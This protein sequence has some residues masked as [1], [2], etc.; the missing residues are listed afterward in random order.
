MLLHGA[1]DPRAAQ[2]VQAVSPVGEIWL[3]LL[4]MT[5]IPL[6]ITQMFVAVLSSHEQGSIAALGGKALLLFVA[7]MVLAAV[8][9]VAIAPIMVA[10]FPT[11]AF[12]MASLKAGAVV[13]E[14]LRSVTPNAHESLGAWLTGLIPT[15]V[16]QAASGS[17][18]LPL[19]VFTVLFALAATR[20]AP[21]RLDLLLRVGRA[22]A[23][24]S[25]VVVR[26]I[27]QITPIGV[28]V[29]SLVMAAGAGW[30]AAGFMGTFVLVSCVLMAAFTVL[31]Y[32]ITALLGRVPMR[33]FAQAV[34]PAQLV[35][36][37]TRSSIASLPALV[38]GA[39]DGLRLPAAATGFVLPLTIAAF[40]VNMT[41]TG[42]VRLILITHVFGLPLTPGIIV[43]LVTSVI[44]VSFT[45][46]G[47]PGGGGAMRNLPAYL[48]AGLPIEA[49]VLLE[50][51][52]VIPDI[53]KTVLNVTG[54][55]SVATILSRG[56]S[57][58]AAA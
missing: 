17:E 26:W 40:R 16:V 35:A 43:T 57:A 3:R 24:M 31:L 55:M 14:A 5:V 53:F 9:T 36:A 20:V 39:R 11:D 41:I 42:P 56:Q 29:L 1:T 10:R 18:I 45:S 32:P 6:V 8:F 44:M 49:I 30:G 19:L 47:V 22:M 51:V 37:S 58:D 13:P 33:R 52:D 15:N 50:A 12:T 38:E 48:A 21:D 27:I 28:F 46:L 34:A 23:D 2:I 4:R 7:L 54:D 25:M